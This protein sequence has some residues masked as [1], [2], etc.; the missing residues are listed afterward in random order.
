[1]YIESGKMDKK[2]LEEVL[3]AKN[4]SIY[5]E[6]DEIYNK[7]TETFMDYEEV[8][9]LDASYKFKLIENLNQP[10]EDYYILV[11]C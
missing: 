11:C 1:M 4:I 10:V 7:R 3:Q 8:K 6:R 5:N 9:M 2:T